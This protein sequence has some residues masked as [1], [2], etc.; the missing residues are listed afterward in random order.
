[1]F[2]VTLQNLRQ[3]IRRR[4]DSGPLVLG[5]NP[6]FTRAHLLVD[7]PAVCPTHMRIEAVSATLLRV[8]NLSDVPLVLPSGERLAAGGTAQLPMP[9]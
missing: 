1:M 4:H 3:Q 9:V 8:D 5:R 7:D 2:V 6:D